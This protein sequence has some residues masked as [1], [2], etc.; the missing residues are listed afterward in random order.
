MSVAPINRFHDQ[1]RVRSSEVTRAFASAIRAV[2]Q[3]PQSEIS[4]PEEVMLE[5]DAAISD[6]ESATRTPPAP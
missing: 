3:G 5:P 6:L 4:Q 1:S 2:S